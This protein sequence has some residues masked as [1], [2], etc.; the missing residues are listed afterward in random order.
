M[1]GVIFLFSYSMVSS[2]LELAGVLETS[3]GLNHEGIRDLM[4]L[5]YFNTKCF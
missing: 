3:K 2:I 1:F 4:L 5:G